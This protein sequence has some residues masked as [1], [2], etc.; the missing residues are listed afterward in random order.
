[1]Q[2]PVKPLTDIIIKLNR[3]FETRKN[4]TVWRKWAGDSVTKLVKTIKDLQVQFVETHLNSYMGLYAYNIYVL[5]SKFETVNVELL[6]RRF[7]PELQRSE[8][9]QRIVERLESGRRRAT[10]VQATDFTQNDLNDKL[11]YPRCF[12]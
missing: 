6:F 7:P 2:A 12:F 10:G 11:L 3:E 8:L 1:M 9:G 4:D 5:D